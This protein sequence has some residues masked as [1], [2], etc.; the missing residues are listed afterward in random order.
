M[1]LSACAYCC[2]ARSGTG[3]AA[4]PAAAGDPAAACGGAAP[5]AAPLAG[6]AAPAAAVPDAGAPAGADAA[7][8]AGRGGAPWQPTTSKSAAAAL[9][10][11][12]DLPLTD[13]RLG[14]TPRV[15]L[16]QRR[17]TL[18]HPLV[19]SAVLGARGIDLMNLNRLLLEREG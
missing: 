17:E 11:R 10:Y 14:V 8:G 4:G 6:R 9:A 12:I 19:V 16:C 1:R 7:G 5:A 2:A 13:F 15:E 3:A 18:L